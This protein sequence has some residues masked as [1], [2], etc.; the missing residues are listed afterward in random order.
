M[1][2][3]YAHPVDIKLGPSILPVVPAPRRGGS[4]ALEVGVDLPTFLDA[5]EVELPHGVSDG[6][7]DGEQQEEAVHQRIVRRLRFG[8]VPRRWFLDL[9]ATLTKGLK[10]SAFGIGRA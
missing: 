2:I 9:S 7:S 5:R 3:T 4:A 10:S 6:H 1:C 8:G